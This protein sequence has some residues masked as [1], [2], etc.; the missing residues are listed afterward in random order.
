MTWTYVIDEAALHKGTIAPVYPSGVNV[1]LA[2]VGGTACAVS[3]SCAHI[4]CPLALG[5]LDGH[6]LT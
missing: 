6:R 5:M 2:R 4:A 1:L 3:G